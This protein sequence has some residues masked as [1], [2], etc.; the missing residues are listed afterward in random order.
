VLFDIAFDGGLQIDDGMKDAALQAL[1]GQG[2]EEGLDGIEPGARCWRE[3][4]DPAG[5]S[6]EPGHDFGVFVGA[7]VVEDDMDDFACRHFTLDG[8]EETD[9]F[10][11][12]VFLHTPADDGSIQDIEGGEQGGRAV[13]DIVMGHRSAF[14]RLEW[15]AGLGAI[16][17]LDLG[18]FIDRQDEG[19]SRRRHVKADDVF[20]FGDEVGII[21]AFEGAQTMR[22]QL[23]SLPDPLHRAQRHPHRFGHGAAGPMGDLTRRIAAGQRNQPLNIVDGDRRLA[24]FSGAFMEKTINTCLGEPPLPAPDRR[25]ADTRKSGDLGNIQ[26]IRRMQNDPST[27]HML[28]SSVTID[29]DRFQ[30]NTIFSRND[31]T[32]GLR[33]VDGIAY[34]TTNVNPLNA[35]VH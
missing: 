15:Q 27:G 2:G 21:R 13:S 5:V 22:L 11:V 18:L 26:P 16:K 19:V 29:D 4:E 20:E 6:F 8:I 34:Q 1:S 23:M 28:L 3:M 9:E 17:S 10:L 35:S 33:H 24:G 30:A 31:G 12:A 14:S 32:D 25:A 7:V